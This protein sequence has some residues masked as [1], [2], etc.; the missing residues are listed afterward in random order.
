MKKRKLAESVTKESEKE[1]EVPQGCKRLCT[2]PEGAED[3]AA[4]N[5]VVDDTEEEQLKEYR[6]EVTPKMVEERV[7]TMKD[8]LLE[9]AGV[10]PS[11]DTPPPGMQEHFK[12]VLVNSW[13]S[14][15]KQISYIY[16]YI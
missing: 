7:K 16:I 14:V 8:Y 1:D 12:P 2:P 6:F 5:L 13:C 10:P 11:E 4:I 15:G 9:I 3:P